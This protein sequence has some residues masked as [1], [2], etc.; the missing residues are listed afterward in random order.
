[1]NTPPMMRRFPV[2]AVIMSVCVCITHAQ[3]SPGDLARVHEKLEGMSHCAD[4]HE[5]GKEIS[6]MKCLACHTEIKRELDMK[7]G[8]HFAVRGDNCVKCHKDHLGKNAQITVFDRNRFDHS[9]TGFTLRGKHTTKQCEDCHTAKFIVD[10]EVLK[11]NR[12]TSLGLSS[13]CVSCHEDRHRGALGTDCNSCHTT[14]AWKPASNFDHSR[15]KFAL[16]GKHRDVACDKCHKEQTPGNESRTAILGTKAFADCTPCHASPHGAKF[17]T[18]TCTSCHVP[19]AWSDVREQQFNHELT[20]FRLRGKH[21]FVKCQ[22]CHKVNAKGVRILKLPHDKCTDCHEDHHKGEFRTTYGNDCAKCHTEEGYRPSTFT[23]ARH[24]AARFKLLGAHIAVPCAQCHNPSGGDQ[25]T[26][27]FSSLKCESCH[28]DPHR[29]QFTKIMGEAGCAKCHSSG[30]WKA[31]TFDHSVTSF[32]LIGKHETVSCSACHKPSA[33]NVIVQFKGTPNRC[34]SC[35][36]DAHGNQFATNSI[37]ACARCH[38]PTGWTV[39]VFDHEK[40]SSFSLTGA[41]K[42]VECRSCH[43]EETIGG[44]SVIRYKPLSGKCEACHGQK[45]MKHG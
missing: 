34:E 41:H 12:K 30:S 2:V 19:S 10:K 32:S 33:T 18:Q 3:F 13:A 37:T 20:N 35:H 11:K 1:M 40:Q 5:V 38:T 24:E 9:Q 21:A 27:R 31:V 15:T 45:E 29:G 17:G 22:Q 7:R 4:C 36:Q 25:S 8:F 16:A 23:L 44:K 14:S 28:K 43:R 42:K 6:G 39:R 26:F